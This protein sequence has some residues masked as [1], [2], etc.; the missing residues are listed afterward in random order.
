VAQAGL[1]STGAASRLAAL[2]AAQILAGIL[3]S[4]ALRS[5]RITGLGATTDLHHGLL[6][7]FRFRRLDAGDQRSCPVVELELV[8]NPEALEIA[9]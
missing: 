9:A 1:H 2:L 4:R 8:S 3:A 6:G 7:C 5:G